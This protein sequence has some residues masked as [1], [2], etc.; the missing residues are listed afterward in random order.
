MQATYLFVLPWEPY[1][2]GGVSNVVNNLARVMAVHGSFAP[3]IA[4][5][6][7]GPAR[8][9]GTDNWFGFEF[10]L[11]ASP[12]GVGLLK[13]CIKAPLSLWRT[14][15]MLRTHNVQVINFHYPGF[16][17]LG[18]TLLKRLG[19]YRGKLLLSYH[20]TDVAP[21]RGAI[22]RLVQRL[23]LSSADRLVA[24]SNSLARRMTSD[25]GIPPQRVAVIFN[26]VDESVFGGET[27]HGT[28]P[29]LLVPRWFIVNVGS[30]IPRKNH[31]LLIEAFSMLAP[32]YPELH[33]CIAGADG[34]ERS[35]VEAAIASRSLTSRVRIYL[36]LDQKDVA[37]LLS[38]AAVCVQPSLAESFPLAVLE[39]AASGTPIVAS[40]IPGH[41]EL[42]HGERTGLLFPLGNAA[43]CAAAIASVLEDPGSAT[44][45]AT[46]QK[47]R[48]HQ[49]FTLLSCMRHYEQL[50]C[51]P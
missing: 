11:L 28:S 17:P 36:D 27:D 35:A 16:A 43:K 50:A 30:F 26:G 34:E 23:M 39:A 37:T 44:E 21:P 22:E 38:K 4:V 8:T 32:R 3:R 24:C 29:Q 9:S 5:N 51:E 6:Q 14:A 1:H 13:A 7:L 47:E 45:R 19:L 31:M 12:S 2:V 40:D 18:V 49:R 20:G 42:I 25:F 48:V 46:A 15:R 33:L 10:S 41:D